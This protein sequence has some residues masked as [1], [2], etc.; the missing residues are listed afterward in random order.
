M[1]R[2]VGDDDA[3]YRHR[4]ERATGVSAPVRPDLD[5]DVLQDRHRL[6]GG[7]L[8]RDGPARRARD[9][10][11]ALLQVEAVHLVDDAVDVIR[12]LGALGGERI[13]I[14]YELAAPLQTRALELTGSPHLAKATS[15]PDCV[16][17]GSLDASPQA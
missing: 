1:Q 10:A 14:G 4:L 6:L 17:A 16:S 11:E 12:Q 2:G 8:V 9:E 5:V 7:K 13:V 3:A 15:T